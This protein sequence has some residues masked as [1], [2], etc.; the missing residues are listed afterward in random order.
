MPPSKDYYQIL[1]VPPSASLEDIK[2]AYRKLVFKYH[3]D[4]AIDPSEG[5]LQKFKEIKDAY[6]VLSNTDRRQS[7]HYRKFYEHYSKQIVLSPQAVLTESEALARLL[8][9]LD[10]YR[11]DHGKINKQILQ[12]L[13]DANKK[14]IIA[15]QDP[16]IAEEIINALLKCTSFLQYQYVLPI[17]LLLREL[18]NDNSILIK[19]IEDQTRKQKAHYLR[20]LYKI[21]AVII[22]SILLCGIIYFL[23]KK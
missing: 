8:P 5:S 11:M 21:P 20:E 18:A 10:P 16:A 22:I 13:N 6:D 4:T 12:I 14:G 3:P 23:V 15:S 9:L 2:K 19:K 7:F 17:H 1:N